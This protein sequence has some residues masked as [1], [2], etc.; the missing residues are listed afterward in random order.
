MKE[1]NRDNI[2]L[3]KTLRGSMTPE[4][5][6]LW[7]D[8][9]RNYPIR[10]QRQK[11][12]GNYIADFYCARARLVI[13]IDGSMH[14][15]EENRAKDKERTEYMESVGLSVIRFTND[16]VKKRFRGVCI[17]IDETVKRSLPP[18]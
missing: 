1:Y 6:H 16:D 12:I 9:L 17:F 3:A 8:Y 14:G 11:A 7:Y 2:S 10:F 15:T 13:E 5:R 4:E 18:S